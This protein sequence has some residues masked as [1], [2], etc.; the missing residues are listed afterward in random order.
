MRQLQIYVRAD[1][2]PN[3]RAL[4]GVAQ[5]NHVSTSEY[6]HRAIELFLLLRLTLIDLD[7]LAAAQGKTAP[8]LLHEVLEEHLTLHQV[9]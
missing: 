7:D 8:E 2:E 4:Q 1:Q 3:I 5:L 6:I 9:V